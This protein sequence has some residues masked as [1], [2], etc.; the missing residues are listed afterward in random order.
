MKPLADIIPQL[1]WALA[2]AAHVY[3]YLEHATS[4]GK[5][6]SEDIEA[7]D[8]NQSVGTAQ[9]ANAAN[10]AYGVGGSGGVNL[11]ISTQAA[12]D[13]AAV[14]PVNPTNVVSSVVQTVQAHPDVHPS[15]VA[16]IAGSIL[17]GLYAAE[18]AIFQ[19]SRASQRTQDQVSLF[20]GLAEVILGAFLHP[21]G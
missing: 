16:S 17:A 7:V 11:P 10:I 5:V 19:V 1:V 2:V 3:L 9:A 18:P 6:V 15:K 21:A 4:K 14:A 12:T 8:R 13:N 20:T